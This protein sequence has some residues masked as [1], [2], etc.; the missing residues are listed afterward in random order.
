MILFSRLIVLMFSLHHLTALTESGENTI[1]VK[2]CPETI[3][4]VI[5]HLYWQPACL[6]VYGKERFFLKD[7]C[8]SLSIDTCAILNYL[9]F[10]LLTI[11]PRLHLPL[12]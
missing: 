6:K 8:V 2:L 3:V 5:M 10:P 7:Q 4:S 12:G 1:H 9:M 11:R